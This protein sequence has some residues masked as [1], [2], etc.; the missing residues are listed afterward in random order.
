MKTTNEEKDLA[1]PA[2]GKVWTGPQGI[3]ATCEE[4]RKLRGIIDCAISKFCEEGSDKAIAHE[5]FQILSSTDARP[6][7]LPTTNQTP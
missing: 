4:N 1:C 3:M 2:C 5:M 7:I 6:K